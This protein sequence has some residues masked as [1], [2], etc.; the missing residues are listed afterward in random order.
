MISIVV[1]ASI[2]LLLVSP[3]A[4]S[5]DPMPVLGSSWQRVV[6]TAKPAETA[7]A[8]PAR[9]MLPD[10]KYFQRK[11]REQRTDNPMNPDVDSMEARSAAMDKAVQ[12]TRTPKADD[13]VAYS[14]TAKVRNESGQ[15][16]KVIFW[17][18]RF[19][20]IARSENTV[21]RQFLC[22]VDLKNGETKDLSAFSTL[23]P[24]DVID[25]ESLSRAKEKLFDEKVQI[26]RIEFS[27]D[28]ILQRNGWK[29]ADVRDA[30]KRAT[31]TPWGKEICRAL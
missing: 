14:Y 10:D 13:L 31:A 23:G 18:Y 20:E 27:D 3:L 5:Q 22:A 30:V 7:P 9:V 16:V 25:V 4:F 21:R 19:T 26:N 2:L 11:S 29:L 8:G 6:E 17:E 12:Q 24:S 15:T 1:K 28:S